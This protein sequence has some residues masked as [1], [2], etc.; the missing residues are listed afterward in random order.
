MAG[1][2]D[3][4]TASNF[5]TH[6]QLGLPV[7]KFFTTCHTKCSIW[8][9]MIWSN[10]GMSLTDKPLYINGVVFNPTLVNIKLYELHHVM[11]TYGNGDQLHT[12]LTSALNGGDQ[13]HAPSTLP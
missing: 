8:E 11:K 3:G 1:E 12:F 4:N 5:Q 6:R 7:P 2:V 13:L 9:V 10:V